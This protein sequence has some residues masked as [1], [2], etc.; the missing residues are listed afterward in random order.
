MP[1][2]L[3]RI[4]RENAWRMYEEVLKKVQGTK[5][6]KDF[7]RLPDQPWSLQ[8]HA[9]DAPIVYINGNEY[10]SDALVITSSDVYSVPLPLFSMAEIKKRGAEVLWAMDA[11]Q[12]RGH[13]SAAMDRFDGVMTWLWDVAARRILDSIDF[14]IYM[15]GRTGKP[16]VIWV[17]TGWMNLFPIH[18]AS[19]YEQTSDPSL[20]PTCVHDLVMSTYTT[21][22]KA[23]GYARERVT[24]L[25]L[26]RL[27]LHPPLREKILLAAVQ[28][29][30]GERDLDNAPK[31]VRIVAD[32]LTP[33]LNCIVKLQPDAQTV[34]NELRGCNIAYFSCHSEANRKDPSLSAILLEGPGDAPTKLTIRNI[35]AMKLPECRLVV[36]SSCE[37]GANKDLFL[38]E[39]GLSIAGA[40]HMA[41]VPHSVSGMWQL[42]DTVAMEVGVALFG[43]LLSS[44][45]EIDLDQTVIAL[46]A[47]LQKQRDKGTRTMLWSSF[48]HTGC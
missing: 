36:L 25:K 13:E 31:E 41:G 2:E 48:I 44:D 29:T 27:S 12:Q 26:K 5:G 42:D 19:R 38:T 39:E 24:A 1:K 10:Q 3:V 7:M 23:L 4:E 21:S 33:A 9:T 20:S 28:T 6:F 47:A 11:L 22:I 30:K 40:F 46:H 18:A 15:N 43:E 35:L 37:S 17:T 14:S 34:R 45:G 8:A 32:A 16:R